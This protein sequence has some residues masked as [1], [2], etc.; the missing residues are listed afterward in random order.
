MLSFPVRGQAIQNAKIALLSIAVFA[1]SA[2]IMIGNSYLSKHFK[3]RNWCV[4]SDAPWLCTCCT[5]VDH[6][7]ILAAPALVINSVEVVTLACF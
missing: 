6:Q 7:N 3:E 5:S 1:P 4:W 2:A